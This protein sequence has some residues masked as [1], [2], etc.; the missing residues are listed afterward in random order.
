MNHS[1]CTATT[2]GKSGV[3]FFKQ[4]V[5]KSVEF[6][7]EQKRAGGGEVG[8]EALERHLKYGTGKWTWAATGEE[9]M[10]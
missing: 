6:I 4:A 8:Y 9:C 5:E 3:C 7:I 10:K 2:K 1:D